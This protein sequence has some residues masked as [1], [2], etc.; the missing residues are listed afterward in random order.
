MG[1]TAASARS[2]QLIPPASPIDLAV[3]VAGILKRCEIS[4]CSAWSAKQLAPL[5]P[6]SSWL[7]FFCSARRNS[8]EHR[9]NIGH[10][11]VS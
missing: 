9:L 5:L 4:L 8:T 11:L 10:K 7:Q 1:S 6:V 3:T 2:A